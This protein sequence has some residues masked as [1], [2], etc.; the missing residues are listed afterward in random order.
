MRREGVCVRLR[1][2]G[3]V[4]VR[5]GEF[6]GLFVWRGV[7]IVWREDGGTVGRAGGRNA[8]RVRSV[9]CRVWG[10]HVVVETWMPIFSSAICVRTSASRITHVLG[11][12]DFDPFSIWGRV[13]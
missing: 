12:G 4:I 3:P 5:S 10:R 1:L 7:S 9:G 8:M 11:R 6:D 2:G 13:Y